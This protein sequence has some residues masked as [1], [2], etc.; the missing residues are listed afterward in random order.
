[1]NRTEEYQ[2][3]LAELNDLP[4]ALDQTVVRAEARAQKSRKTRRT[5]TA[6]IS[7]FAGIA[8]AFVLL[9][10][11][12][13]PFAH[14][15]GKIPFLRELAQAVSLSP[16]LS[17]A[18][19]N[20][21]VQP[22][23]QTKSDVGVT[24]TV[25]YL[26]VD[27]RQMI[28][29]YTL[30][31]ED[32]SLYLECYPALRPAEGADALPEYGLSYNGYADQDPDTL[33]SMTVI[34]TD[35]DSPLPEDFI[36]DATIKVNLDAMGTATEIDT[37][38]E[39]KKSTSS[40][41]APTVDDVPNEETVATLSFPIHVDLSQVQDAHIYEVGQ[42]VTLDGQTITVERLEVYPTFMQVVLSDHE[43]NTAWL[44]ALDF[45]L[46]DNRGR[47]Y[48]QSDGITAIGSADSPFWPIHRVDSSYFSDAKSYTLHITGATWLDKDADTVTLNLEDGTSSPLPD[49]IQ[50]Y[51]YEPDGD[52]YAFCFYLPENANRNLLD[53]RY[54]DSQGQEGYILS[55]GFMTQSPSPSALS[56]LSDGL[57]PDQT[58]ATESF[59]VD[60]YT[61]SQITFGLSYSR[62]T[63]LDSPV[64]L[65][66]SE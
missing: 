3:L 10:N 35:D 17:A 50:G 20:E 19:E 30:S 56:S 36:L 28:L 14:A 57:D 37:D 4:P 60:D 40:I 25:R 29:F 45:Y 65:P 12:S 21:Y 64:T 61:D 7:S 47:T 48:G 63:D 49:I 34:F 24:M 1:M 8:A 2:A 62:Q 51:E 59:R 41:Y 39:D 23:D 13:L 54:W 6:A 9:V 53:H 38:N 16:S 32:P 52:G 26:I 33:R 55:M 22:I 58:Y 31:A 42:E 66:I 15:C 5:V 11:I 18:V 46:T 43:E 44:I 27:Q